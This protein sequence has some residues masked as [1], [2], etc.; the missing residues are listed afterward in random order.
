MNL[1]DI[2]EDLLPIVYDVGAQ[3][4]VPIESE[5]FFY[6]IVVDYAGSRDECIEYIR[7]SLS[8]WFKSIGS[9][10][11]WLQEPEWQ[12]SDGKPMTFVGQIDVE[13]RSSGFHDNARFFVFWSPDTGETKTV[14]QVA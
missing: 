8:T 12:F 2:Y 4:D 1:D 9:R 7:S 11:Q 5:Q 13:A 14:I 3:V 10:P 6:G